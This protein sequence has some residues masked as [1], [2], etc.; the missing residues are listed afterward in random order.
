MT[1]IVRPFFSIIVPTF[2]RVNVLHQA[3]DS[4]VAQTFKDWELL[5]I[6]DG[7]TDNTKEVVENFNDE[8]I[9]YIYQENQER[10]AARNNGINNSIGKFICFLDSDDYYLHDY[11]NIIYESIKKN[12]FVKAMYFSN[13]IMETP[14][15][16]F[17][18]CHKDQGK[19]NNLEYLFIEMIGT[20]QACICR[21]AL[22]KEKFNTKLSLGEDMD[23]WARIVRDFPLV[24]IE[25][26]SV[27]ATDHNERSIYSDP[28]RYVKAKQVGRQVYRMAPEN[29][30]IHKKVF[31]LYISACHQGQ[32][33]MNIS[34]SDYL[35]A[36]KYILLA[37]I[38]YPHRQF[39]Y[40]INLL[41]CIIFNKRKAK[42]I[43]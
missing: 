13:M 36:F 26:Y 42:E 1:D 28:Q 18:K 6:D 10:S 43:I 4:V 33:K 41:F 17:N 12:N 8:R 21:E 40:R 24:H 35:K 7:S 34:N 14:S 29:M 38:Y 39:T 11:L 25:A 37:I 15:G 20:P 19:L 5:I 30:K 3:I 32:A 31:R 27:V 23:L 22:E 2:N 9:K 16:K